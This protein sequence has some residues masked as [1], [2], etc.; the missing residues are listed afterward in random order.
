M[1]YNFEGTALMLYS[2][3]HFSGLSVH[4]KA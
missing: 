1:E 4:Y 3:L 2:E